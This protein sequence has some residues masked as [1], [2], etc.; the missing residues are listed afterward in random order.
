MTTDTTT[1]ARD[2]LARMDGYCSSPASW[3]E[4]PHEL[5]L[6]A[7]A[8]LK[9]MDQTCRACDPVSGRSWPRMTPERRELVKRLHA[10]EFSKSPLYREKAEKDPDYWDND[11]LGG[12]Y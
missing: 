3:P 5:V 10:V 1:K 11:L 12:I 8:L 4:L 2:L 7:R 6:E 9:E